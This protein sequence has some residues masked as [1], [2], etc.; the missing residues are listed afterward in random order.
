MITYL[1]DSTRVDD[2]YTPEIGGNMQGKLFAYSTRKYVNYGNAYTQ[3]TEADALT[4]DIYA[5]INPDYTAYL[6]CRDAA[7]SA[8]KLSGPGVIS[9][10][11]WRISD[12]SMTMFV[13]SAARG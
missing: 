4:Q 2:K 11:G 10:D 9:G 6:L 1:Q 13:C 7:V 3:I 8:G 12:E 5:C